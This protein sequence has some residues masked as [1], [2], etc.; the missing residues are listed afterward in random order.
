M[1]LLQ[2]PYPQDVA[3]NDK[4]A[5]ISEDLR[6]L[7]LQLSCTDVVQVESLQQAWAGHVAKKKSSCPSASEH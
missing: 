1:A 7:S 6:P 3:V 2:Q 4:F 5:A